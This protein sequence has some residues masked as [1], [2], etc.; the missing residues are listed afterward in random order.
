MLWQSLRFACTIAQAGM[1]ASLLTAVASIVVGLIA[2]VGAEI[3]AHL[4]AFVA[5]CVGVGTSV[6]AFTAG[7]LGLTKT[8]LDIQ[9]KRI[10]SV[11]QEGQKILLGLPQKKRS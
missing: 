3:F 9:H 4:S 6:V 10:R 8:L 11:G 2:S 1:G 7:A 5:V